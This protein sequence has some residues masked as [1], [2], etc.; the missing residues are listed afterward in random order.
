MRQE[1]EKLKV[2]S[3]EHCDKMLR[4]YMA[5]HG[6]EGTASSVEKEQA[7]RRAYWAHKLE[8]PKP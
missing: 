5:K 3:D 6:H 7:F 8:N 4:K 2:P 1:A